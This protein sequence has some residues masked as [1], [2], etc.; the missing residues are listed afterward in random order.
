[1]PLSVDSSEPLSASLH[2]SR[3]FHS[4]HGIAESSR[5]P[6][7]LINAHS[8]QEDMNNIHETKDFLSITEITSSQ[9]LIL[10]Q[11]W[12]GLNHTFPKTS[13]HICDI[14]PEF[15]KS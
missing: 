14:K 6:E 1:M 15:T 11:N 3:I 7:A 5:G 4:L 8:I 13:I 2:Q 9:I 10:F 12:I